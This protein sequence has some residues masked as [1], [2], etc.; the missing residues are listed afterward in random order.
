[1]TISLLKSD[2]TCAFDYMPKRLDKNSAF[3]I[4]CFLGIFS[5]VSFPETLTKRPGFCRFYNRIR[6]QILRAQGLS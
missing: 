6:K 3:I 2:F 4:K 5:K 1:M